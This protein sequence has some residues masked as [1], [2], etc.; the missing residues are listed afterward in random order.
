MI[1]T[2]VDLERVGVW[3]TDN[4]CVTCHSEDDLPIS[5]MELEPPYCGRRFAGRIKA[6]V[7]CGFAVKFR[8]WLSRDDWAK[9]AW[10]KHNEWL[11]LEKSIDK[12]K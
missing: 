9:A 7:C 6:Y 11:L 12:P 5:M 10:A 8:H 3:D 4:C 2:C 1:L